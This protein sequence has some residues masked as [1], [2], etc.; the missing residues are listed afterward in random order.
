MRRKPQETQRRDSR[1]RCREKLDRRREHA[2]AF[3]EHVFPVDWWREHKDRYFQPWRGHPE[4]DHASRLRQC[5]RPFQPATSCGQW[6]VK[7][8]G[9]L[10]GVVRG[11]LT[12]PWTPL[13]D[14]QAQTKA[15]EPLWMGPWVF[16]GYCPFCFSLSSFCWIFFWDCV[17]LWLC[18]GSSKKKS[19]P[20]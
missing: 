14:S 18:R 11:P 6:W 5:Q 1:H 15:A 3:P 4:E 12:N 13:K 16:Q 17:P 19:S 7:K 8:P 2:T 20:P 10:A 9:P